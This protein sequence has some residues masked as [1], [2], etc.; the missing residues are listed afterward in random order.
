ML[1]PFPDDAHWVLGWHDCYA[2]SLFVEFEV[3]SV[4][5]GEAFVE[6]GLEGVPWFHVV[7]VEGDG[8]GDPEDFWFGDA[9]PFFDFDGSV[10]A[11]EGDFFF[12]DASCFAGYLRVLDAML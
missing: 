4:F 1:L 9:V 3:P 10:G 12:A 11:L 2:A 6:V 7:Y 5:G 8:C